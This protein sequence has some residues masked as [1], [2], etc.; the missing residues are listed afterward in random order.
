M[1]HPWKIE[2]LFG[3]LCLK[4][5]WHL[6]LQVFYTVDNPTNDWTGGKG[7]ISK[8]MAAKGLP[9]PGDDTLI[10]VSTQNLVYS[11]PQ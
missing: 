6:N 4:L 5:T 8:D 7:Y 10:L 2:I 3:T 1:L 11:A 9:G